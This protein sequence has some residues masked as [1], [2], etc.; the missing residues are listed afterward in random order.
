MN[1]D[2]SMISDSG[3]HKRTGLALRVR[4]RNGKGKVLISAHSESSPKPTSWPCIK[5]YAGPSGDRWEC[6]REQLLRERSCWLDGGRSLLLG[7]SDSHPTP[8]FSGARFSCYVCNFLHILF[9]CARHLFM[10]LTDAER[11]HVNF[12]PMHLVPYKCLGNLGS[13][14]R[15]IFF[16]GQF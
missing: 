16:M 2:K 6:Q 15:P 12:P 3:G 7:S 9:K 1:I 10:L 8:V 11:F 4:R 14:S 5:Q 13:R